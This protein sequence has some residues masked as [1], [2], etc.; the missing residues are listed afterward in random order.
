MYKLRLPP[1][2]LGEDSLSL[3]ARDMRVARQILRRALAG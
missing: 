2:Q 1:L 3:D